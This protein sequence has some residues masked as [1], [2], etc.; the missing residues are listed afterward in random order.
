MTNVVNYVEDGVPDYD[1]FS[2]KTF[3]KHNENVVRFNFNATSA[4]GLTTGYLG[5]LSTGLYYDMPQFP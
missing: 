5:C 3:P 1:G 2:L 4:D